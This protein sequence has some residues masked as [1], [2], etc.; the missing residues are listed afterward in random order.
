MDP[1]TPITVLSRALDQTGDVLAA[2][3]E[4]HLDQPTPCTDWTVADLVDH[5][6]VTP[7]N[8][9]SMLNGEQ[10]DWSAPAPRV[11][12][13]WTGAFR[14]AADDLLHAWHRKDQSEYGGADWQTADLAVHT[15]DLAKAIGRRTDD[16]DPEVAE[17]GLAF[18]RA[19]LTPENRGAAFAAEQ[20]APPDA[21]PYDRIAAFAGR[22]V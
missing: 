10:P 5:V 3:H 12:E 7:R 1:V 2:V 8:F 19:N 18:L 16:L 22:P 17:R 11:T 15:W 9:L 14:V 21:T 6:V 13:D 4:Q 20:D